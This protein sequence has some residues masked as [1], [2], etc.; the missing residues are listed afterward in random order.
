[1]EGI[2]IPK[3]INDPY[4]SHLST[5][6]TAEYFLL[7]GD[8]P[9]AKQTIKRAE[10]STRKNRWRAETYRLFS[11]VYM[12]ENKKD[13]SDFYII[14][15]IQFAKRSEGEL[16]LAFCLHQS[17]LNEA[18]FSNIQKAVTQE[19][20]ALQLVEKLNNNYYQIRKMKKKI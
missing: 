19:L 16:E 11:V 1:M 15:A 7:K 17:A 5:L 18:Q 9:S 13:S 2:R 20:L 4:I 3:K 14:K 6:L 8:Y 10:E 12:H